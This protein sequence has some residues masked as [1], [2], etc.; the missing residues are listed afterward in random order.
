MVLPLA[1]TMGD[2][3]GC[4]PLITV[5][6]WHQ[7]RA[8]ALPPFYVIA[9][10][11]LFQDRAEIRLIQDPAEAINAFDQALPILPL[12]QA[13]LP[14]PQAG[15]PDP[16]FAAS[17]LS[18][19]ELATH[20]TLT[21]QARAIVTNPISKA[22][23]YAAGFSHPGHTEFLAALC[24]EA[25]PERTRPPVMML[26]GGGLRVALM[27]IHIPLHQVFEQLTPN[28]MRRT[29]ETVLLALKR[30]FQIATPRLALCGLNPHAGESGTIGRE[31]IELINPVAAKLRAEGHHVTD[32]RPGD[33][34]FHEA[35]EGAYDAVLAMT[36]DQGLIPVK[37]LDF[38]GG[39]NTTLGLPIIR[40]SPDHGTA[41]DAAKTGQVRPDSLI[42]ALLQAAALSQSK[43]SAHA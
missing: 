24:Q 7:R 2:P 18:S 30:D 8:L 34:V 32:A 13:G 36:H 41:Y 42:A 38:W 37:T 27:T 15:S 35:L 29:C 14:P 4:G 25:E 43:G 40:T 21:G 23:L 3:A 10:P 11:D 28:H 6:A 9:L 16:N 1:V 26:I 5:Q 19:I 12:S 17:I 20:H 22:V 33:T 39:V 31:E